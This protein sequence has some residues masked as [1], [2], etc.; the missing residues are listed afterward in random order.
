MLNAVLR[1]AGICLESMWDV[2]CSDTHALHTW[3]VKQ[4]WKRQLLLC[5]MLSNPVVHNTF[6]AR[7]S[8]TLCRSHTFELCSWYKYIWSLRNSNH[9]KPKKPRNRVPVNYIFRNGARGLACTAPC[10]RPAAR[11]MLRTGTGSCP[12]TLGQPRH[13]PQQSSWAC[14]KGA[15]HKIFPS[16]ALQA[17]ATIPFRKKK[18]KKKQEQLNWSKWLSSYW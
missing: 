4:L 1:Q 2:H 7:C 3:G 9:A 18:K 14:C 13:R 10:A 5:T 17:S 16:A 11:G 15:R 6:Y 12:A 8:L